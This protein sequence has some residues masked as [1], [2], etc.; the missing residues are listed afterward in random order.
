[1]KKA[2]FIL[3]LMFPMIFSGCEDEELNKRTIINLTDIIWYDTN[4]YLYDIN[5]TSKEN[6]EVGTVDIG[7]SCSVKSIYPYY[8]IFAKD[9]NGKTIISRRLGFGNEKITTVAK[10]DLE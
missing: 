3:V 9:I 2:L 8:R 7:K 6:I 4:V 5:D 10:N 1:M